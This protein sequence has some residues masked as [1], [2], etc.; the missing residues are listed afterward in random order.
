LLIVQ[1]TNWNGTTAFRAA[2]KYQV[3]DA[4]TI[5]PSLSYQKQHINGSF[6]GFWLSTWMKVHATARAPCISRAT[7]T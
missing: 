2:L 4:L 3:S 5:T 6:G 7:R 1:S